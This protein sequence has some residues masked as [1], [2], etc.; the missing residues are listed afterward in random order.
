MNEQCSIIKLNSKIKIL[1]IILICNLSIFHILSQTRLDSYIQEGIENNES[2]RQQKFLLNKNI[3][4]LK[5]ARSM[6]F[7][8]LSFETSYLKSD[9]GR[10]I[11]MPVGDL[12]NPV[13]STLNELTGSQS[14]PHIRNIS[15]QLNPDNYYDA[16]IRISMPLFNTELLYNKRLKEK[17]FDMQEMEISLF[18][19]EL[20]KDI[21][22]AYYQYCQATMA[23]EIRE[24]SVDLA[25][26][27]LRINQSLQRNGKITGTNVVRSENEVIKA[28]DELFSAGQSLK[29]SRAYFNFLLN[30]ALD[31]PIEQEEENIKLSDYNPVSTISNGLENREEI[32]KIEAAIKMQQINKQ[33]KQSDYI[34]K[35]STFLDLGSQGTNW[36]FNDKTQY[37]TFGITLGWS[38]SLG[39]GNSHKIKQA[40]AD[41]KATES[42]GEYLRKQLELQLYTI[43][44]KCD[45]AVNNY[46][47]MQS[48]NRTAEKYYKDISRQYKEGQALY[49][50]LL[51]AQNQYINSRLQLN[52]SQYNIY[53]RQAQ[54]ERANAGFN[55]SNL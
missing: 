47:S 32:K 16:K 21:K 24:N 33:I 7:P 38:F 45:E 31:S 51:D 40:E 3:Y 18:K 29:N 44:N 49:I 25:K 28:E 22:I 13:Y 39:G 55:L 48:Q 42:Q 43:N 14:F 35:V 12:L 36:K 52:I 34:P 11:D 46:L 6:F 54:K 23:V 19:R 17:M 27:N 2:I 26:E 37:Y 4:A 1:I 9:G 5:E 30:K 50:E 20:V 8:T 10:A 53:I 41:V 15:E